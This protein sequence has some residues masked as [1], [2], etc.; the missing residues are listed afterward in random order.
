MKGGVLFVVPRVPR[1]LPANTIPN[2]HVGKPTTLFRMAF[3]FRV[4]L[5]VLAVTSTYRGMSDPFRP[6][7]T[8]EGYRL[9]RV[10]DEGGMGRVWEAVAEYSEARVALKVLL[11]KHSK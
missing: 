1:V 4:V 7:A 3:A 6:G 5:F 10:L 11:P 2:V 9:V 8:F